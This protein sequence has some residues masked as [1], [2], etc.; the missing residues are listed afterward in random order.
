[1]S[2]SLVLSGKFDK[3]TVQAAVYFC[4]AT[5]SR[6]SFG[7]TFLSETLQYTALIDRSVRYSICYTE[8]HFVYMFYL[9][10]QLFYETFDTLLELP[11]SAFDRQ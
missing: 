5:L 2:F 10:K 4:L 1:M 3:T 7:F 6:F 8:L 11:S 9:N